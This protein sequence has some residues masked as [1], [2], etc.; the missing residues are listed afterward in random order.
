MLPPP[1]AEYQSADELFQ[2]AQTFANSQGYVLVK[3]RTRKDMW[4]E[5]MTLCCDRGG[6]YN[7]SNKKQTS[8]T[9]RD[10]S[11]FELMDQRVRKCTLCNQPGHNSHTC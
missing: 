8:S 3:K 6:I 5:N 11:G 7:N 9:R 1:S 4:I 2:N 10:P